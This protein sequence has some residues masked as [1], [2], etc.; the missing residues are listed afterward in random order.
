M[1]SHL[2]VATEYGVVHWARGYIRRRAGLALTRLLHPRVRFGHLCD[3]GRGARFH[4][5][6][7]A[8]VRLGTGCVLDDGF[9]VE[10]R[11]RVEVGDRTVFGHHC[12]VAADESVVIGENCL[13]A[14]MVSIRDHDHAFSSADEP[15]IDQGRMTAPVRI[16]DN[17]WL[18]AKATVTKGVSIGS[19]AVIGA[20]AVVTA[21]LPANCVAVGIPARVISVRDDGMSAAP[22]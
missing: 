17:V 12:T 22:D 1:N 9:T 15:F 8:S 19:N 13:I 18:G 2:S 20:H 11:G 10:S 21:D 14:E 7:G 3:V 5:A 6:Q 4:V 16:G